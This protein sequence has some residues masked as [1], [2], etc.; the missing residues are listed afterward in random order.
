[1]KILK[2]IEFA[3]EAHKGQKRKYTG[4][5]YIYHPLSVIAIL[6]SIRNIN[7]KEHEEML[8][9]AALHDTVED[10]PVTIMDI[11]RE[12]GNTVA[13]LVM[14][15]TDVSKESDDNRAVRKQLDLEHLSKASK[16]GQTIKLAD[17]IDNTSSILECDQIF[18]KVYMQEKRELLKVLKRGHPTLW[19]IATDIVNE[20][21][22]T[23]Q[24][25]NDTT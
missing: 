16:I 10:T 8:I 14:E 6:G 2:A 23:N 5:D 22:L 7:E 24:K 17:L 20:Y 13:N 4:E 1:M 18:A 15:V 12:F 21:F 3:K 25:S 19:D 11:S 9:A